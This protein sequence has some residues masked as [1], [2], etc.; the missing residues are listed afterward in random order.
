MYNKKNVEHDISEKITSLLEDRVEFYH[1]SF[2]KSLQTCNLDKE[3]VEQVLQFA[4]EQ[5]YGSSPYCKYYCVHPIRVAHFFLDWMKRYGEINEDALVCSIIHN[6]LEKNV[7]SY[8]ELAAGYGDWTA[9]AILLLTQDREKM[10]NLDFRNQYY[11]KIYAADKF[12]NLIKYF[13]KLDNIYAISLNPEPAVRKAYIQEIEDKVLP[14][15]IRFDPENVDYLKFL[16]GYMS[17][18]K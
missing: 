13:D 2:L 9:N 15:A 1:S 4:I 7:M 8:E 14:I 17:E 12:V 16:I 3:N 11:E 18:R 5:D 6:L 10:K